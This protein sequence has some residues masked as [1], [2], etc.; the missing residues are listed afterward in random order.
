[1]A[2][3]KMKKLHLIGMA[4]DRDR[5][6]NALHKTNAAEIIYQTEKVD[7]L[8]MK[9]SGEALS[10]RIAAVEAALTALVTETDRF[11]KESGVKSSMEKDGFDVSYA[12]F[13]SVKDRQDEA[14]EVLS[15]VATLVDR[16]N[17]LKG[18]LTKA[19]R[20][21][22]VAKIYENVSLPFSIYKDTAHTRVRVGALPYSAKLPV[23]EEL[24]Q[25][26]LCEIEEISVDEQVAVAVYSHKDDAPNV[27]AVLAAYGFT[28]C[29]YKGDFSGKQNVQDKGKEVE[30]ILMEISELEQGMY[31]LKDKIRLLKIYYDYLCFELEKERTGE[32]MR[33]TQST[34]L[35]EGYVPEKSVEEVTQALG[36]CSSA[37]FLEF[38][39]PTDEDEPPTLLENNSVVG[40]FEGITNTFAPPN[41]REFDPNL[42]MGIFYSIFMGFIIGDAGYGIMM[43]L[44]G[45]IL[46]WKGRKRPTGVSRLAGAF[47]VGG[48]F[49][50][51]W[52][53]LFN[54]LFG[55]PVFEK[56]FMPNAQTDMWILAGISVPS[57]LIICMVIGVLHLMVGYVCK[58]VQ[59]WRRGNFLDGLFDGVV[60]ALF[61]IG[62]GLAIVG[63]TEEAK[64]PQLVPVGGITAGVTLLIAMLTAGRHAKGFGKVT[65]GFGAA[66]GVI[67][68]ASDILSYARLYGLMLSGA[69][70]AGIIAD[71][72]GQFIASGNVALI[73]LAVVLLIVGNGFNLVMNLLGAYIHDARL[74]YVEFYGKF[75]EGEGELFRPLG[76][77][78]RYISVVPEK[79]E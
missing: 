33:Q 78:Y 38:T 55:F 47:A 13:M 76:G 52:G 50:I 54:S 24:S 4:Y 57:V 23:T 36:A 6:L 15:K 74:Q 2:I 28:E 11:E 60:W 27:D 40:C 39:D 48:V 10:V 20:E 45:G 18:D 17:A 72:S 42:I 16:R 30:R 61:S 64:L 51:I 62:V 46:W 68:Y 44:G 37:I 53:L 75:Y 7:T 56:A 73:I 66:Y 19:K 59:E 29:P 65:K 69:V 12:E 58:A 1:V 26:E 8:P 21:L 70:I 9:V 71:Y 79:N 25:I 43:L 31:A 22:D 77:E 41:Y 34:L 63:F 5:I 32:K 35:L 3:A 67:N 14:E 49:A